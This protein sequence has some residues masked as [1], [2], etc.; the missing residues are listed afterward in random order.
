M[1]KERMQSQSYLNGILCMVMTFL[2]SL[3]LYAPV[4][5]VTSMVDL[6]GF[7]L[8]QAGTLYSAILLVAGIFVFLGSRVIDKIGA[9][10]TAVSALGMSAIGGLIAFVAGDSYAIHFVARVIL[11]IGWGLFFPLPSVI[12][13]QWIPQAQQSVWLSLRTVFDFGGG[14]A[15]YVIT[16]HIFTFMHTW[17]A[18]LGFYGI[19]TV[20]I[21]VIYMILARDPQV[22]DGA[23]V[24]GEGNA[25]ASGF[26][27]AL[28]HKAIILLII[29]NF[30][31]TLSFQAFCTYEPTYLELYSGFS[32][33]SATNI[34]SLMTIGSMV[35]G[36]ISGA[37]VALLGRSKILGAPM[38]AL[39][40]I[41]MLIVLFVPNTIAA[42]VGTFLGGFGACGFYVYWAI[43]PLELSGGNTS[44]IAA[45]AAL[46]LAA[47]WIPSYFI[48]YVFQAL[49]DAGVSMQMGMAVFLIPGVISLIAVSFIKETSQKAKKN[50]EQSPEAAL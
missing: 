5:L 19:V 2:F 18:T 29:T 36:L 39:Q 47:G 46:I 14:A 23:V 11:G 20:L 28:R 12:I 4:P 35:A 30:T 3:I 15:A 43:V 32:T 41:G 31:I 16:L 24:S 49:L 45:A 26:K 44:F 21:A 50:I 6:S 10:W 25:D 42:M 13:S 22:S 48:P 40:L 9:K 7:T 27:L 37:L 38:I 34:S 33:E 1:A 17:Q 8:G